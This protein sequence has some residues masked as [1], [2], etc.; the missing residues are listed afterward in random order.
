[1]S[2]THAI[3]DFHS[4]LLPGVDDG[5]R[6]VEESLKA[7]EAMAAQGMGVCLT[8]PHFNASLTRDPSALGARLGAFDAAWASLTAAMAGRSALPTLAR[9]TEVMLDEPDAD[10]S[11]PRIRLAGGPFVLVEFPALRLPPNAEW[12]IANLVGRGWRPIVAHPERYRNVDN[13]LTALARLRD[14]GGLFQLNASSVVGQHGE[15]AARMASRLLHTGWID[16]VGSDHHARGTPATARALAQ[17]REAGGAEQVRLLSEENPARLLRGE[18]PR[19]V[20][21]LMAAEQA[22]WWRRLLRRVT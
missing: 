1:V 21:P 5:A 7:L 22:A 20:P 16:Y 15:A 19:P 12:G 10:L 3:V 11:D 4:H 8:T 14:A 13:E 6:S 18:A 9:G 2:A 17:L